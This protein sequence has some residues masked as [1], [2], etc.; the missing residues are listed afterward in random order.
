MNE[1]SEILIYDNVCREAKKS[2]ISINALE[3]DCGL[4]IGSVCKWN[5]VSPTV[6][7]LKKVADRL[8]VAIEDLLE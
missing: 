4:A 5:S 1:L 3:K 8:G 2:G 6:R 7:S